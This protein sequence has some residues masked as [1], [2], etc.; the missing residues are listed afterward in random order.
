MLA[1]VGRSPRLGLSGA[2]ESGRAS[3]T[4]PRRTEKTRLAMDR[5][6]PALA[7]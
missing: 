7:A 1:T 5:I 3:R 6:R 4:G 2:M